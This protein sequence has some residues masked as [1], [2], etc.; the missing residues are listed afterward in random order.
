MKASTPAVFAM[1]VRIGWFRVRS[2]HDEKAKPNARA[3]FGRVRA[4]P[5]F[6]WLTPAICGVIV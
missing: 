2:M 1:V 6:A 4:A 3:E 5:V